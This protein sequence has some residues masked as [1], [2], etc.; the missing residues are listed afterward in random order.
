MT[1]S[2]LFNT[3]AELPVPD[4]DAL[5]LSTRL[6]EHIKSLINRQGGVI[7]FDEY[8]SAALYEPGLGYYSA[9]SRKF[10][11]DGDFI[12]APEISP[13]FS[14]CLARQCAQILENIGQGTILEL[15]AGTGCMAKD[16]LLELER[17]NI[18]PS[19][20]RILEV[21]ADLKQR[22]QSLLKKF[23]NFS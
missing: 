14:R 9:G 4:P 22:Q 7:G 5:L 11:P 12:T 17:I 6:C 16:I 10:G 15:G 13:L 20:Y 21:S 2:N 19:E 8:M 1:Q 18:L 3:V 23:D